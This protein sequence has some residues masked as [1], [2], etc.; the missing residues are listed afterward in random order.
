MLEQELVGKFAGMQ[1]DVEVDAGIAKGVKTYRRF[2][3]QFVFYAFHDFLCNFKGY[4]FDL[5]KVTV[6]AYTDRDTDG[7]ILLWHTVVCEDC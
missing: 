6:I 2:L 5:F 3:V 1:D 7:D 4:A